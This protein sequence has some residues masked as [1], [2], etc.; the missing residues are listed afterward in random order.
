MHGSLPTSQGQGE[1]PTPWVDIVH[2]II[3][4]SC[5]KDANG[6]EKL[7]QVVDSSTPMRR[8]DLS[9]VHW[10]NLHSKEQIYKFCR[11]MQGIAAR[12]IACRQPVL[13]NTL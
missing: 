2:A 5:H 3:D 11:G 10:H 9:C 13:I 1:S 6:D 12:S 8:S 4:Q 7:K